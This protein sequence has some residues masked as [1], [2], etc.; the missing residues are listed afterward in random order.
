MIAERSVEGSQLAATM[1]AGFF[2]SAVLALYIGYLY[3]YG[4]SAIWIFIGFIAGFICLRR[5]AGRIKAQADSMGVYSMPEY[6]YK[7]L[8]KRNG[9]LFSIFLVIQFF[10]FLVINF[11]VAGEVF[12]VIFGI[13]YPIAVVI[14][15]LIVLTYLMMAGF[16]A[17]IKTDFFQ[18]IITFIMCLTV[19]LFFLGKTH[20]PASEITLTG[21]GWGNTIGFILLGIASIIV[22]PDLWQRIFASKN[23][24][25]L[26]RG[27]WYAAGAL[28]LGA[29]IISVLGLTTKHFFPNIAP[30]DALV[31]GFSQLLPFGLK[32]FG[33]VLLYAVALSS[34]D[35]VIFVLSSLFTRDLKNYTK[36]YSE[37]SMRKLTRFIMMIVVFL[38]VVAA[39]LDQNI[40]SLGIA[41]GSLNLALFPVVIGSLYWKLNEKAV[42]WSLLLSL[43]CAVILFATGQFTPENSVIVLPVSLIG[44]LIF[45]KVFKR[46]EIVPSREK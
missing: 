6:F 11:I 15:A 24:K 38:A 25:V 40:V 20:I 12:S 27:L 36:K 3:Q 21:L 34:S 14:G 9:L 41:F 43:V 37:E 35:T 13:S 42:F 22:A 17:V 23:E 33:M 16:K 28:A 8:G 2:D 7:I 39:L 10:I 26:K 4:F 46:I 19:G 29:V 1:T 31:T 5:F 45:S 18:L 32:E 44:L 30:Q